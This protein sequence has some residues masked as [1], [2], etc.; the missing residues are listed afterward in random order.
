MQRKPCGK[1]VPN[2][3][4]LRN[5]INLKVKYLFSIALNLVLGLKTI[6]DSFGINASETIHVIM[7]NL[8]YVVVWFNSPNY[9]YPSNYTP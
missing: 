9:A 5:V 2:H 3:E 8:P 4:K 6:F 7:N 1:I